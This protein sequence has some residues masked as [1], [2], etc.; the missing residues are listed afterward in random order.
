MRIRE[1]QSFSLY[2]SSLLNG[3]NHIIIRYSDAELKIGSGYLVDEASLRIFK[4][5][6]AETGWEVIGGAVDTLRNEVSSSITEEGVY[7]AFTTDIATSIDDDDSKSALP[8]KFK[9]NQ[10]YSNPFNPTTS[11]SFSLPRALK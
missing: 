3:E 7:A 2:P 10:N 11:I 6:D 5:I 9:L 8:E 4:W 1:T